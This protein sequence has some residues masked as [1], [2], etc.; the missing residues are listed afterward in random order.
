MYKHSD[1]LSN[2]PPP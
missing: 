2:S 1:G